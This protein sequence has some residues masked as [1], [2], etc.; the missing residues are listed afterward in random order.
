M[1]S[2]QTSRTESTKPRSRRRH[3]SARD[4]SPAGVLL[5][6]VDWGLAG[7]VFVVPMLMGGRQ[8]LG[9]FVLVLLAVVVAVAWMSRQALLGKLTW[10]YSSAEWLLAGGVLLLLLQTTPLSASLLSRLAP[11]TGELLPLW[12]AQGDSAAGLGVWSCISLTP[13]ATWGALPLL[14]SYGMLFL[15]TVQRIDTVEDVERLLRWIAIS[16]VAMA[17]FGLVQ[18][19]ASNGKFFWFYEHPFSDTHKVAKGSFTNRNHFAHFLALGLGPLIWWLQQKPHREHRRTSTRIRW[20]KE[21]ATKQQLSGLKS[22]ALGI[23]LF[24]GLMSLSRGGV[25]AMFIAVAVCVAV[26][27]RARTLGP[28]FAL[29]LG[30]VG[31]L[32]GSLLMIHGTDHLSQRMDTLGSGS[33][34]EVDEGGARR[35]IWAA[36][37]KAIP[38]YPLLGSGVGSHREVYPMYLEDPSPTEYTHAENGYLQTLLEMGV[39]GLAML[40]AGVGMCLFWCIEGLRTAASSRRLVCT[41]AILAGISASVLHS[42][43]DFVWY[44]PGCMAVVVLLAGCAFRMRQLAGKNPQQQAQPL[45]I[46]GRLI[47]A[48]LAV[49]LLALG[50]WMITGRFGAVLAE[51]HWDHYRIMA[52]AAETGAET[53]PEVISESDAG[54]TVEDR[55]SSTLAVLDRMID[56]LEQVVRYAPENSRARLRLAEAYVQHFDL[57]QQQPSAKLGIPLAQLRDA[58]MRARNAA[59]DETTRAGVE[60]WLQ[61]TLQG[62]GEYLQ[63]ALRHTREGLALCP[64]QGEGYLYLA[65]LQF[66]AGPGTDK[67]SPGADK[68]AYVGQALRVRPFSGAVLLEAGQEAVL[69]G[70]ITRGMQYWQRSFRCGLKHQ[71]QLVELLAG[72]VPVAMLLQSLQ[73]DLHAMRILHARYRELEAPNQANELYQLYAQTARI[74]GDAAPS[75]EAAEAW[76]ASELTQLRTHHVQVAQAEAQTRQGEEALEFWLEASWLYGLLDDGAGALHCAEAALQ[77]EPNHYQVRYALGC[78]LAQEKRF[79]EAETHL[80]WC[81]QRRPDNE[82]LQRTLRGVVQGRIVGQGPIATHRQSAETLH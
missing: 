66:L 34:E 16:A 67:A 72:H 77:S 19:L 45:A 71:Y 49:G 33:I 41:G 70:D 60:T 82:N 10:R 36:V 43:I 5:Q 47:P 8:A 59:S 42:A 62:Q 3:R 57:Q 2:H 39:V 21:F 46:S 1:P 23:V 79:A 22:L 78:A 37:A 25:L 7:C 52:L 81:E 65:K 4:V 14:L 48:T 28:R 64:L 58:A 26:C 76:L 29:G 24:A 69:A 51:P 20:T 38:N 18:L 13:A 63:E 12:T 68:S 61:N 50:I 11:H 17:G 80:R 27:Y 74:R 75:V 32:I 53:A 44:V 30:G 15:V 40:V 56:E 9:Q 54:F 73:P 55:Q 35:T 6:V 31:L